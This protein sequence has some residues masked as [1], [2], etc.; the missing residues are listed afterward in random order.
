MKAKTVIDKS[1]IH[2]DNL[3][4]CFHCFSEIECV[5]HFAWR[6]FTEYSIITKIKVKLLYISY[7][8]KPMV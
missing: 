7:Y 5:I 6:F 2:Y 1:K 3:N 8:S 4:M